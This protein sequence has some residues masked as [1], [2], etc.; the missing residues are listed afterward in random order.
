MNHNR[1]VRGVVGLALLG[2]V[3]ACDLSVVNVGPVEDDILND[4]GAYSAVVAGAE[5]TLAWSLNVVNF[6]VPHA[7]K[8]LT[9]GGRIHPIKLPPRPGQLDNAEQLP[10]DTWNRSHRARWV[11]EDGVR[12]F[13]EVM[14]GFSNSP[15]AA[16]QLLYAGYSNRMLGENMCEAVIDSGPVQPKTVHLTAA[17]AFFTE[18][19]AVATA[20]N[21]ADLA[22]AARAGRASVRLYLGKDAEAAADAALV[23]LSFRF[24]VRYDASPEVQRNWI[25]YIN[26]NT[27]YRAQ[28]AWNTFYDAYFTQTGDPRVAWRT[29]P[30]TPNAEFATVRYYEQRKYT[31]NTSPVNLSSGREMVLVR[32]EVLLKAGNWQEAMTLINSLRQGLVSAST[33][34]PVPLWTATSATEAWTALKRERGIELWLEG[35]RLGDLYRWV[36][37]NTPGTMENVTDRIRLCFPVA[38]SEL[39]SNPNIALNHESPLNP[40]FRR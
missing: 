39:E 16:Q 33:G 29:V 6:F 40:L 3:T 8:E 21:R 12:R 7:S 22:N 5:W 37:G 9:Q 27:P 34:Q 20:A 4:P 32:A 30:G 11:A 26:S 36:A 14:T 38:E 31:A 2:G 24:Q 1:A 23:P 15:M 17:E 35:R 28:S 18:A 13:R 10:S 25:Y 19:L